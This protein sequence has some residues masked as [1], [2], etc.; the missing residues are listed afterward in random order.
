MSE[1]WTHCPA[2]RVSR[3][4]VD[5]LVARVPWCV[6]ARGCASCARSV[7]G[8]RVPSRPVRPVR[9][10]RSDAP[11]HH[12]GGVGAVPSVAT[13]GCPRAR[14]PIA[15][16]AASWRVILRCGVTSGFC[17]CWLPHWEVYAGSTATTDRSISA[18][19]ETRRAFSFPV[20]MPEISY[21][22]RFFRPF[23]S[24]VFSWLK[25]R[26]SI[27]MA[28]TPQRSAQCRRRVMAWRICASR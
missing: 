23:F 7:T 27:A 19:I 16:E 1:S 20:G 24:R 26:S 2:L 28:A 12:S 3:T 10:G 22:N 8:R 11:Y 13:T 15:I 25:S 9:P 6:P 5:A 21:R 18:A 4:V 17:Q 14:L